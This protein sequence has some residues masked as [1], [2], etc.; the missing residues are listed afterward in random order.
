MSTQETPATVN[1]RRDHEPI[2]IVW[3]CPAGIQHKQPLRLPRAQAIAAVLSLMLRLSR[4]GL[5]A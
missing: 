4:E 5:R 3:M 2:V 1:R